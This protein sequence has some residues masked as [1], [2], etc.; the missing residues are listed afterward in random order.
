MFVNNIFLSILHYIDNHITEKSI[1]P[2][3]SHQVC[4]TFILDSL[5]LYQKFSIDIFP[6]VINQKKKNKNYYKRL[7]EK[8]QVQ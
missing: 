4:V 1:V 3:E 2:P 5:L 6:L 8:V 7:Y